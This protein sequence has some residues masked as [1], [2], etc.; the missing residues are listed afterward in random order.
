MELPYIEKDCTF[1]HE[2]HDYTSGGTCVTPERIVA[3]PATDGVLRD[4]H[5]RQIGTYRVVHTRRAIFFGRLSW[6]GSHYYYMRARVGDALYSL[7]GFGVGMI[8]T[9]KRIKGI[10]G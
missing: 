4:W 9:G 7:R 8:A 1:S 6:H 5:G 10:K 3:Y 2:G